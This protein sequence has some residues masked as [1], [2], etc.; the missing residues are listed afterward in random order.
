MVKDLN[1]GLPIIPIVYR[2]LFALRAY[3]NAVNSVVTFHG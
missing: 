1:P 2:V 3:G